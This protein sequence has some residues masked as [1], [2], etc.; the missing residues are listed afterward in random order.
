MVWRYSD[1]SFD[2]TIRQ[3]AG[4]GELSLSSSHHDCRPKMAVHRLSAAASDKA[5]A[6]QDCLAGSEPT[7]DKWMFSASGRAMG[8]RMQGW[9]ALPV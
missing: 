6:D 5:T 9:S 7:S 8:G 4:A 3:Q 2:A 1:E